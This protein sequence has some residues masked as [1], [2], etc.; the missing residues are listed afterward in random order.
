M[1]DRR[2]R[3]VAHAGTW[4]KQRGLRPAQR[5]RNSPLTWH[6]PREPLKPSNIVRC[7]RHRC[8]FIVRF[9]LPAATG[10]SGGRRQSVPK[11]ACE[12]LGVRSGT[13]SDPLA[14]LRIVESQRYRAIDPDNLKAPAI[15]GTPTNR[16]RQADSLPGSAG[17]GFEQTRR[18]CRIRSQL[19]RGPRWRHP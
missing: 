3:D 12:F 1:A 8:H 15:G 13:C 2:L 16:A 14:T 5:Q 19:R 17:R 4:P 18:S 9:L 6:G 10:R 11:R 7:A